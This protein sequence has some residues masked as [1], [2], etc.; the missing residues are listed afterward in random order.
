[1][2]KFFKDF[3]PNLAESLLCKLPSP[4]NKYNLD[5]VL[6]YYSN[7]AIREVFHIERTS[8]KKSLK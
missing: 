5:P 7:F 8:E 4:S 1:M 3:F 2:S 6:L